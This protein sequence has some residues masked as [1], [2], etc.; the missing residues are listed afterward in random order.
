MKTSSRLFEV[1]RC[2]IST[3]FLQPVVNNAYFYKYSIHRNQSIEPA[4]LTRDSIL[5]F[6]K[7][8]HKV[9][10]TMFLRSW[11]EKR[12]GCLEL[13]RCHGACDSV[14]VRPRL[15]ITYIGG[16]RMRVAQVWRRHQINP[17]LTGRL[18]QLKTVT[19]GSRVSPSCVAHRCAATAT[20]FCLVNFMLV[21][22]RLTFRPSGGRD[23]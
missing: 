1:S 20:S 10:I 13:I 11:E 5:L 17:L 3:S 22:H 18:A 21:T 15:A 12:I 6:K 2:D 4:F 14:V 8:K 23:G 16:R 19:G 7:M 9:R